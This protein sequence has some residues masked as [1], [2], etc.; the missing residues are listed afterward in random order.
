MKK[1]LAAVLVISSLAATPANAWYRGGWGGGYYGGWGYGGGA[2]IA[3]LAVGALAGAAIAGAANPYYG[4][5]GYGYGYP[6]YGYYTQP[7]PVVRYRRVVPVYD[8]YGW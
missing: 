4:G 6:A 2:A 8:Y 1:I 5:Y 3:G 7:V